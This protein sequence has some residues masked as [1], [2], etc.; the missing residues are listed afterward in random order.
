[1]QTPALVYAYL[2]RR[3]PR[4]RTIVSALVFAAAA[5]AQ[6]ASGSLTVGKEQFELKHV[7]A[8]IVKG[9]TRIVVADQPIP[10]D[11]MDDEAQIWDLKTKGFHGFQL[12]IAGDKQ[13]YSLFVISS[14]VPGTI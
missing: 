10:P 11:V 5:A 1:M 7:M 8:T 4:M 12:D 2:V 9:A 3:M 13:N 6:T 14:S